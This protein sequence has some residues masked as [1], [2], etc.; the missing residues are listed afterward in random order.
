MI[1]QI[2]LYHAQFRKK[3]T[4]LS[5]KRMLIIVALSLLTIPAL[6]ILDHQQRQQIATYSAALMHDYEHMEK[7]WTNIQENLNDNVVDNTLAHDFNKLK[8]I[9]DYRS[10]LIGLI[11]HSSFTPQ[12]E[13]VGYSDIMIALARLHLPSL[14]LTHIGIEKN[15]TRLQ[16]EGE[17]EA[18]ESISDY[19]SRLTKEPIFSG[20]GL[21]ILKIENRSKK[22]ASTNALHFVM[23]TGMDNP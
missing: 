21:E 2:N 10:D 18:S 9:F 3:N 13:R 23:A 1:P 7:Q 16:I 5:F 20:I 19:L 4:R 8:T 12:N 14:W 22:A 11:D 17:T 15:G 6:L